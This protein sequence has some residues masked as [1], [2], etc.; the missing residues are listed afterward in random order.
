MSHTGWYGDPAGATQD[1][2][3]VFVAE[4]GA[5]IAARLEGV[6]QALAT[7]QPGGQPGGAS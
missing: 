3:K 2:A 5:E 1:E 7:V 6:L 4:I